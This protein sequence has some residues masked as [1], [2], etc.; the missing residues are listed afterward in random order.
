MPKIFWSNERVEELEQGI[1]AVPVIWELEHV[2]QPDFL[3]VAPLTNEKL[4]D[5][6]MVYFILEDAVQSSPLA[7]SYVAKHP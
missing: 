4:R 1:H 3:D 7:A 5:N 2:V 6:K